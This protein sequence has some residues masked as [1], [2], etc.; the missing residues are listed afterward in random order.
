MKEV[1]NTT[2]EIRAIEPDSRQVTGYAIVFN[3]ES[4]GISGFTEIISASALEGVLERSDVLC[5]LNHNEDKGVLARSN[6]GSG[7]LTL[8]IDE[9]G[10]KYSFDAPNTALGDELLEGLKRGDITVSSFAFTVADGG[11]SWTKRADGTYLR[12]INSIGELFDVSPVYR[13]AY[14]ATSVKVDSRGLDAIKESERIELEN[15]FN[16]LRAKLK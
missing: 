12:T 14:D 9:R 8:E 6:K 16:E 7:S 2:F 10:L 13:A 4:T 15:Y 5:L 1:R 11:D 3:T